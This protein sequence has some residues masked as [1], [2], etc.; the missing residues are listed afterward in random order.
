[1][2]ALD[3]AN[4]LAEAVDAMAKTGLATDG[5][6]ELSAA[7]LC[8]RSLREATGAAA[9]LARS[10]GPGHAADDDLAGPAIALADDAGPAAGPGG[11]GAASLERGA[12]SLER[13]AAALADLKAAHRRATLEMVAS[14]KLTASAAIARVD[15]V[16]LLNR[17]AHHAWRAVAHLER[18]AASPMEL[19]Q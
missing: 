5:P 7:I 18:A 15:T 12:A 16:A 14:G 4:R 17:L 13:D 11:S 9:R 19:E 10:A 1:V 8:A 2:H 6:E 3:H